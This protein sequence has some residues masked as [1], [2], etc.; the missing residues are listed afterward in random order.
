MLGVT[1]LA[2][3]TDSPGGPIPRSPFGPTPDPPA[4]VE[5]TGRVWLHGAG[6][7]RG[8]GGVTPAGAWVIESRRSS[9][10]SFPLPADGSFRIQVPAGALVYLSAGEFQPCAVTARATS[11]GPVA[12]DLHVVTDRSRLGANLPDELPQTSLRIS[13]TVFEIAADGTR[14]PIAGAHVGFDELMGDS[15]GFARTQSGPDG[16]YV[17]CGVPPEREVT[18]LAFREALGAS[19]APVR[20]GDDAV[21][22][23][24]LGR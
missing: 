4:L 15:M 10:F 19:F 20:F 11:P 14:L 6:G 18:L 17:L 23:I 7:M 1:V 3:C 13:G 16:R 12:A 22:D 5:I 2:G 9:G 8:G 21:I 24:R